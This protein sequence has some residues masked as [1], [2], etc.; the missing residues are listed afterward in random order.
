MPVQLA[1]GFG[2]LIE[3]GNF[4]HAELHLRGN[5]VAADTR[6]Q[7]GVT[8]VRF[9][10]APVHLPQP[11]RRVVAG[12]WGYRL[13]CSQIGHGVPVAARAESGALHG[14]GKKSVRPLGRPAPRMTIGIGQHH[15]GW[16]V[17]ILSSES[18]CH[19]R[20]HCRK[21]GQDEASVHLRYSGH[22]VGAFG[23]HAP[24]DR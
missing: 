2:F 8:R 24:D 15:E 16:Q 20:S 19:P 12:G 7:T 6:L 13:G 11:R 17:S 23:H 14:R 10:V 3:I 5:F 1:S 9:G 4:G 18:V 22:V 21:A